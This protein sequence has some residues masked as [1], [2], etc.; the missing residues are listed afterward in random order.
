MLCT[1]RVLQPLCP[2]PHPA[3]NLNGNALKISPWSPERSVSYSLKPGLRYLW[4]RTRATYFKLI[5]IPKLAAGR[6]SFIVGIAIGPFMTMILN[7]L[8]YNYRLRFRH[9][10]PA[11]QELEMHDH[12]WPSPMVMQSIAE[13]FPELRVLKLSQNAIWCGLCNTCNVASFNVPPPSPLVYTSGKGLPSHY[14]QFLA[15]LVH[16]QTV[17][18]IVGFDT[19]GGTSIHDANDNMWCGECDHCMS[20]MYADEAF[21]SEWVEKKKSPHPTPPSLRRVEWY[22]TYLGLPV[23]SVE[24]MITVIDDS[25]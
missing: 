15:P 23:E 18:L 16:L 4:Q 14:H 17:H 7:P 22:F 20:L 3:Q 5:Y 10:P 2:P 11:L 21:R 6:A 24:T 25:D 1:T 9:T 12:P 13:T 19:D 8:D